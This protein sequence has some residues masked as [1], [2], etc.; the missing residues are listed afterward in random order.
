MAPAA[1]T[2]WKFTTSELEKRICISW[3][4]HGNIMEILWEIWENV[5]SCGKPNAIDLLLLWGIAFTTAFW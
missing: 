3:E 4:Y 5:G 2:I 1:Q